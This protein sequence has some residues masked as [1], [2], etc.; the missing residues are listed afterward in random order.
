MNPVGKEPRRSRAEKLP[1]PSAAPTLRMEHP[2]RPLTIGLP[3]IS[4]S[5]AWPPNVLWY[6]PWP[7]MEI[8]DWLQIAVASPETGAWIML[9]RPCCVDRLPVTVLCPA[10]ISATLRH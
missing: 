8:T 1:E 3:I 2:V 10:R 6:T 9:S 7:F 4:A 5:L